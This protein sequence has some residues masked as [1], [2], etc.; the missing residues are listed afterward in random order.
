MPTE[1]SCEESSWECS[2]EWACLGASLKYFD[3]NGRSMGN[4]QEE[5][6]VF[7][8]LRSLS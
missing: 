8:Q 1:Q 6:E 5:L 4:Q 7:V 2:G 3:A